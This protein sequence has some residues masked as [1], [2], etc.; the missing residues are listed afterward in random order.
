V[1]PVPSTAPLAVPWSERLFETSRASPLLLGVAISFSVLVTLFV[2][3]VAFG[4]LRGLLRGEAVV[5]TNEEYR[6]SIVFALL[7]GYLPAAF[8]Y[9]VRGSRRALE[10]LHPVLRGEPAEL[11]ELRSQAGRFDPA[12]LRRAGLF[13]AAATLTIPFLVD[14]TLSAY[15][16]SAFHLSAAMHRV[17]LPVVGWLFGRLIHAVLSDSSRFSRI[18]RE[19]VEV[20]LLDLEPLAPFTRY[21]LRNALLAMG[22]LSILAGL[23]ADWST[24]PGLPLVLALGLLAAAGL[25]AAGLL[26]PVRGVHA[27]IR[28]AKRAELAAC[29]EG[30][31]A[32][33]IAV[34]EGTGPSGASL[35]ELLSWREFVESVREWPFDASTFLRFVLY[36]AIPLGSWLGGAMVERVVDRFLE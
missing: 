34:V 18:G 24:R 10:S 36:L 19:R 8:A 26:L 21:G 35:D 14:Q 6:F 22:A 25:A 29:N 23:I 17:M 13:G 16:F 31:R 5:W 3:E 1:A 12:A 11:A 32:R 4:N 30:I 2:L 7:I 33:R 28:S 9:A 15:N 20:D 27:A